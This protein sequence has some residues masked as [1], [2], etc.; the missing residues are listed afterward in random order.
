M[1]PTRSGLPDLLPEAR[2]LVL[3]SGIVSSRWPQVRETCARLGIIFDPWQVGLN[4]CLLGR[5]AGGMFAAD[6]VVLSI[7]RQV[8]KTFDVG[9]VVFAL[10]I[11]DPGTTVV[12]TAH[13]FK[14]SRETFEEL[15]ALAL[16]PNMLP[17]VDPEKITTAAGNEAIRFRNGSRIVF[18]ARERGAVRGFTKVRILILDEG[19]ILTERA[20]ADML[21][22]M[23]QAR[24]PMVVVMGTPPK[25][26]DPGEVFRRLRQDA[27]AGSST[28]VLYVELSADPDADADD[29]AQWVKANPSYPMRTPER[30][31]LRLQKFLLP[32][33][34]MREA[35]GVWDDDRPSDSTGDILGGSWT[36]CLDAL[37][38]A[39]D[40]VAFAVAV[41]PLRDRATVAVSDGTHVEVVV[42]REGTWWVAAELE[43]LRARHAISAIG[44]PDVSRDLVGDVPA[45]SVPRVRSCA[46]LHDA[47]TSG[48]L[49]HL[50]QSDLDADVAR[51]VPKTAG[52]GFV[53]P[54]D[55]T[56]LW[57]VTSALWVA[58]HPDAGSGETYFG[59][60]RRD[61][62][63]RPAGVP[64]ASLRPTAGLP[65]ARSGPAFL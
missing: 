5:S 51:A 31:M 26:T 22:T 48:S 43:R 14:V 19:Q 59:S 9:A 6:T 24:D 1:S 30:A 10:C 58:R 44:A 46:A 13:Q 33:D 18:A 41:S 35:L 15:R 56:S 47:V 3:P 52:E 21:P 20:L 16:L 63:S 50:G 42:S 40:P 36:A 25:P 8:G 62:R 29:R 11:A 60:G 37:S 23:N 57:A 61:A 12:W 53:W 2:H 54:A 17:H 49:R 64:G 38:V 28:D 27:L 32:D 39:R 34:W 55:L 4:R 45:V 7:C 65:R